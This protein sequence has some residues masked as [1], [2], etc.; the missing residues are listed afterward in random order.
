[1]WDGLEV[2]R[3][4]YDLLGGYEPGEWAKL[5]VAR[6]LVEDIV[7]WCIADPE[8][9]VYDL[10]VGAEAYKH[11]W[12]DHSLAICEYL[13][14]RSL[15]GRLYVAYRRWRSRLKRNERI[16]DLARR[17]RSALRLPTPRAG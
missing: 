15:K 1:M 6:L 17:L 9:A 2:F 10:T 11:H 14:P 3:R 4:F 16:R 13:A 12:A 8:V 5:S 7:Q